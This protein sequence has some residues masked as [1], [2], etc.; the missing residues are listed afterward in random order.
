MIP[1]TR[2]FLSLNYQKKAKN[3]WRQDI[4]SHTFAAEFI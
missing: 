4:D 1:G 2:M 3:G